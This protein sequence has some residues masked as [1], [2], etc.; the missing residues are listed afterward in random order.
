MA[1]G[2]EAKT[3]WPELLGMPVNEA[4]AAIELERPDMLMVVPTPEGK[5]V[6]ADMA[7]R[8]VRVWHDTEMRVTRIPK[9]G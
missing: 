4:V 7:A 2:V 8:R 3:S 5:I 1:I 6:S 9:I